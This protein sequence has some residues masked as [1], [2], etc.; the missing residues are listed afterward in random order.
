MKSRR[1][2]IHRHI[3]YGDLFKILAITFS[4]LAK[5]ELDTL[6]L[7]GKVKKINQELMKKLGKDMEY[8]HKHYRIVKK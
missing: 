4:N 2:I 6:I 7:K 1:S 8:L 5:H 3:S